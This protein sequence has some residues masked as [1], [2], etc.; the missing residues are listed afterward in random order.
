MARLDAIP[1]TRVNLFLLS[2]VGLLRVFLLLLLLG[3]LRTFVSHAHTSRKYVSSIHDRRLFGDAV[4][5][6][7]VGNPDWFFDLLFVVG[8]EVALFAFGFLFFF[9]LV[10]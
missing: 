5:V 3:C 1:G 8:G 6:H 2:A 7:F 4:V 9:Q 10:L